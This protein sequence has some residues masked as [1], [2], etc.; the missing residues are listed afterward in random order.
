MDTITVIVHMTG[1]LLLAPSSP[2][3]AYPLHVLAPRPNATMP[4]H[5]PELG[6]S[7]TKH[8]CDT[9]RYRFDKAEKLCYVRLDSMAVE[10]GA[11][12]QPTSSLVP[13]VG[14]VV[15]STQANPV[16][17]AWFG[18]MPGDEIRSRVTLLSGSARVG[19]PYAKWK[20]GSTEVILDNVVN[21]VS[22]GVPGPSITLMGSRLN[23]DSTNPPTVNLGTLQAKH[24][25]IEL[26]LRQEPSGAMGGGSGS[27][28]KAVH[29][30][31]FYDVLGVGANDQTARRI[32]EVK[33]KL[34]RHCRWGSKDFLDENPGTATCMPAGGLPPP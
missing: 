27:Q 9:S 29:F 34:N 4:H 19:C 10:L 24:G 31:S 13:P 20:V 5:A 3:G 2:T 1:L 25:V 33:T 15:V 14:L 8:A 17:R 6:W 30:H 18:N 16:K 12:G 28:N 22:T 23:V 21:W 26:W 7:S 32:P 11:G